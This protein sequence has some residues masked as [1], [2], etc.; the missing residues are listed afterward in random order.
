MAVAA[1][2]ALT[3]PALA[4]TLSK[5]QRIDQA[6]LAAPKSLRAGATVVRYDAKGDP[7]VLRQ[8]SNDIFCTP[9]NPN[10]KMFS[11]HCYA[12]VLRAQEDMQAKEKAEGK[13]AKTIRADIQAARTTDKVAVPPL[14]TAIYSLTGKTQA[15]AKGMWVLLMPGVTAGE[16]DLPTRP[17]SQGTPWLMRAG[18]PAAHIHIPQPGTVETM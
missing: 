6:V 8:G 4:Q 10:G 14:G 3:A 5:Q 9:N 13:D 12:K 17:T 16:T 18:T 2:V 15:A 7:V 11:V 1:S